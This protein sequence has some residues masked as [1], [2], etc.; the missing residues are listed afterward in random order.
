MSNTAN[1]SC[2]SK[3]STYATTY[4]TMEG[5]EA[6]AYIAYRVNENCIIYPITPSS[7]MGELPDQWTSEG[8]TNIFGTV[9]QV[10]E[11]QSEA[12]AS[13]AI[14]GAI[15]AGALSTTF[16]ASQGLLLMIPNMYRIAGELT[17]TVFHVASRAVASQGMSIYCEHSDVMAVRA[18]GFALL[19]SANVQEAHDM[20]L[21]TQ[22]A[23]LKSKVPFLHFFD[24]FR[25]SHEVAKIA[26]LSDAQIKEL[27]DM[28]AI[29]EHRRRQLTSDNPSVRGIIYNADTYFQSREA[30]S[31][32]YERLP[33]VLESVMQQFKQ[34]TGRDYGLVEYSGA[35]DAE[36]VI[37][38]MGSGAETVMET[39]AYLNAKENAKVGVIKIRLFRPF[40]KQQF[41]AA[42][43]KTCKSIAVLDRTKEP[44]A[45]GEPLYMEVATTLLEVCNQAKDCCCAQMQTPRVIAGRYG[46][47]SKEFTPAMVKAIFAELAKEAPKNHF[48]IGINDD[49][50][51]SSLSYD[52]SFDIEP[53]N[54]IRA[55]FY[56]LGAD[57]TVGANKNTIK[58]IGEETDLHVQAYF[59]YD[60]KKSGSKTVSHLRFGPN[61]ILSTYLIKSANFIACHQFGF[62]DKMNVLEYATTNATFLLNSK[63]A[64]QEVWAHL[65]RSLQQTIIDKKLKFFVIDA[66][67]VA[68]ETGMGER[69]NTIMQTC[70]FALSNVLPKD[71]AI[72]KIKDTIRATYAKK[73]DEVV[74]KNFAAVDITLA[75]LHEVAIPATATSNFEFPTSCVSV[76]APEFVRNVTAKIMADCGDDLPVSAL[77][78][79]GTYPTNTTCWEKR[80]IAQQIPS[81]LAG[82]CIQCGQCS[83]VCP[84]S[85]IRV[86]RYPSDALVKEPTAFKSAKLRG[87]G[88]P[89]CSFTLQ[90]YPEDCTGCGLCYEAC[91]VNRDTNRKR[92]INM[93]TKPEDLTT[94]REH[95]AF[96][97]SLPAAVDNLPAAHAARAVTVRDAQY[98]PPYFEFC[99]ACAGCGESSYVRL[100]T[101]LFG[102]RMIIANACGCSS[103]YGGH[104]PTAPWMVDKAGRGPAW[105]SSL[106]ED[107]A[108]FGY[109]FRL[110]HDKHAE[111][112]RELLS[113]ISGAVGEGLV[114]AILKNT[115]SDAASINAQ[116]ERVAELKVKLREMCASKNCAPAN[117]E[118]TQQAQQLLSVA[119]YLVQHSIWA[120]GGDGWAY[121]IG[122][123]GLD[124]VLA[125]GRNINLLV[126]DT[127][128]YSNTGGQ[129]SKATPRGAVVKFAAQGKNTAKKDLGL[130]M[131]TYGDIYVASIALGA[132]P[133]Q[134]LQAI[135][136]A[137]SYQGPSM[138]IA[139]SHCIAHGI[140]MQKGLQQQK[141]AV[142]AGYWPLYRY[143]PE[144]R[145]QGLH[146]FQLDSKKPSLP[147]KEYAQNEN[148]YNILLRSQPELAAELFKLA[149]EDIARRWQ[150]YEALQR[151][152]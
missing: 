57:G 38:L 76:N 2:S 96:F 22:V 10:V 70:F 4:K 146:P 50:T 87:R 117:N 79:D 9:P 41:V 88:Y 28:D 19:C 63:Y 44:G 97:E 72:K 52:D 91:P 116:R 48:T 64:A 46:I 150:Q 107:N 36:R 73:G 111:F 123:A 122:Y 60:S 129:A 21:I 136:E 20:A 101:Q 8:I 147:F 104:S 78:Q 94:E 126:L 42:I 47:A 12:G 93:E 15:Q 130:I 112:A 61:K 99:G 25:T 131:M 65:P 80:N 151:A 92:A 121:D 3:C 43:P 89:D 18:T 135:L 16:T 81:W 37:V 105:S 82:A 13:G 138:I 77:P 134:A 124:H 84:H 45:A 53:S 17:P 39:V 71:E 140:D 56:G 118:T 109:G 24:G 139:Y 55:V 83:M 33:T 120:I 7:P 142:H 95:I 119:D 149:E 68:Q 85:A 29:F 152:A 62:V 27:I 40:P 133:T 125:S 90:V 30:V 98:L 51:H 110:A 59:V 14:H 145:K 32:C 11:M 74:Q 115:Q 132:D 114:D 26:L 100:I 137:E 86:K 35:Q 127:E 31:S 103:V 128:V 34:A 5:N 102:D 141:L 144:R 67:K 23:S 69:I 75:G 113:K 58:I 148:R 49:V 108:E 1:S 143:N 54:V 6:V 66:Y 106:F